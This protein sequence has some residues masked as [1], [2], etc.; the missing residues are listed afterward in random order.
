MKKVVFIMLCICISIIAKSQNDTLPNYKNEIR[1]GIFQLFD[2]GMQ[3]DYERE[4]SKNAGFLI[5]GMYYYNNKSTTDVK[6]VRIESQY[7]YYLVKDKSNFYNGIGIKAAYVCPSFTFTHW[8]IANKDYNQNI[9]DNDYINN[10]SLT[11]LVG[12]KISYMDR[13]ILDINFGGGPKFSDITDNKPKN[14]YN[15]NIFSTGYS[16][17]IPDANLTFGFDF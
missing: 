10:F 12:V 16:G 9:T 6:S 15:S 3:I 17:I 14:T 8:D 5:G 7:R 4:I 2:G 11:F 1:M 13:F